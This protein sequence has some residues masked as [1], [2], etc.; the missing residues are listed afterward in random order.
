MLSAVLK[1]Y[2]AFYPDERRSLALLREQIKANEKL[3][4]RRNFRGHITASAI[5]LSPDRQKILLIHHKAYN[6]WQQPGGHW[7]NDEKNPLEAAKREAAEE[8]GLKLGENISLDLKHPLV[9]FDIDSHAVPARPSKDEPPHAHHDFRYIFLASNLKPNHQVEEV[10]A[11]DWYGF[12][13]PK[14]ERVKKIIKK[15]HSANIIA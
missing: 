7:E 1:R 2:L 5:I 11:A 9:P 14:A 8:T 3:N 15:L 12:N 10:L 4:N 6:Q 13:D